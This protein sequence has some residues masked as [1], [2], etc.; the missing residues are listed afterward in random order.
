MK[1]DYRQRIADYIDAVLTG[2]RPAG[3]YEI[4]AVQR[5][6]RDLERQRSA[7]FPYWYDEGEGIRRCN[8]YAKLRHCKG[9]LAG[10]PLILEGWEAFII[11]VIFGWKRTDN[12]YRRFLRADVETARKNG[13]T[14]LAAGI[15]IEMM[16][17]IEGEPGAEVYAAAVDR[18]QAKVCW[19]SAK[20]IVQ[21]STELSEI[22]K[23]Y[24][25]SI[26]DMRMASSFK[27]LSKDTQNKD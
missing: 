21:S 20:Q 3:H 10:K 22:F 11:A 19:D 12:N 8:F 14:T 6:L 13:K 15:G 23:A 24:Q 27:P 16:S 4:C 26:V 9:E 17:Q 25:F 1:L 2:K 5:H 18:N 7:D